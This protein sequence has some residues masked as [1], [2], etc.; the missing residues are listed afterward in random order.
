MDSRVVVLGGCGAWP[1]PGRACSGFLLE[2]D[3]FRVALDLGYG[4]LPR[5]LSLLGST[6]AVGLDAVIVTHDH[7][8]HVV[9]LHGLFRARLYDGRQEARIQLYSPEAVLQR[10]A[11]LEDSDRSKAELVFAWRP[12]P[13]PPYEL[14]PLRLESWTLPHYVPN[15][16]VRLSTPEL[17]VAYTGDTGPH[18]ALAEVGRDADLYIVDATDRWQ[19]ASLPPAASGPAMN[20]TAREAGEAAAAAGADRLML[21]HFWPGNDRDRS[22]AAAAAVFSGEVL[23]ADEGAV[24]DL[25]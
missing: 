2:H 12:L 14:G 24:V 17:T 23:I 6:T 7:P 22:R 3:G 20:L 21:T 13:A 11:G 4:T 25:R 15:A 5:L 1:E 9:D 8:D 16:G 18:P 10:I 19:Q